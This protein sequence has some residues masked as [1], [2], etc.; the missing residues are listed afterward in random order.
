MVT[1]VCY[2]DPHCSPVISSPTLD[3]WPLMFVTTVT[4]WTATKESRIWR[5]SHLG[6][7]FRY[8]KD[9][10]NV[11]ILRIQW[12]IW[13]LT[14]W[15]PKTFEVQL[16]EGQISNGSVFKRSS[17]SNGYSY[18]PNHLKTW[19][20]KIQRFFRISNGLW[21]NGGHLSWF[22]MVRLSDPIPNQDHLQPNLFSYHSKSRLVRISDPH[23]IPTIQLPNVGPS[24]SFWTVEY[25]TSPAFRSPPLWKENQTLLM[26]YQQY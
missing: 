25:L 3:G 20:F 26:A 16:F 10:I 24:H 6:T 12:G 7:R 2:S 14:I 8:S 18:S 19:P 9:L 5:R 1:V 13:N 11:K 22:Q 17:F 15:N 23:C 21:Q 4:G